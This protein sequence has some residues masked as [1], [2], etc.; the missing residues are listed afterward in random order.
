VIGCLLYTYLVFILFRLFTLFLLILRLIETGDTFR[1]TSFEKQ[2]IFRDMVDV[3]DVKLRLKK[4]L[5]VIEFTCKPL[6]LLWRRQ[7]ES[8]RRIAVLQSV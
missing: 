7:S 1:G 5:Q 2:R 8:N 4:G 6:I 3:L